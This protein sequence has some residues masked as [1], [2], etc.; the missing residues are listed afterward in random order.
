MEVQ[1]NHLYYGDNLDVLQRYIKDESVDLVYLDPPFNSNA[2]YNVLFAERNGQDSAAQIKAFEDTWRW[3]SESARVHQEIVEQGGKLSETL[4]AL[5]MILGDTDMLAYLTMMS[6]RLQE[7]RRVLKPTGSLYLHCDPTASHYL[8]LILDVIFGP[9]NYVNE[10]IWQRTASKGLMTRRLPRNHDVIFCY[11]MGE[12]ATRNLHETFK[13]YDVDNLDEKTGGKYRL[14]D[15]D[16][17]IYRL[18][19]LN[20]PN[21]NRPNLTYEFLGV[22][23]VWRW[24]KDRMEEAYKKGIVIQTAPGRVPQLKRYLDEQRG[25]PYGDVWADIFPINSQAAERLGYPTQKPLP[26]LERIIRISSNEGDTVLDPFC[27]CG[28]T[29]D[30]AERLKRN[31]IGIDITHLAVNL[32]KHRL[33]DTYGDP[34]LKTYRVIGEPTSV[35]DAETLAAEDPYQF[36]WW[37]L[38]LVGARPTETKKG[39]DH[40]IDGKLFFHDETGGKTKQIIF[41]VK[42]GKTSVAHV[43]DLRG[44]VEREKA[45]IGVLVSFQEPT[46]PMRSEAA[47]SGFYQSPWGKHPKIQLLTIADLLGGKKVDMPPSSGHVNVTFKKAKRQ[48]APGH[49]Q[50]EFE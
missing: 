8:K 20:N 7:L 32:I 42:A 17:R 13:A 47:G 48:N 3:D 39:A 36:Q 15:P 14:K 29:I 5:R 46:Q 45:E 27:G 43:R 50:T 37:A 2:D 22:T 44:V 12:N 16:G 9:K 11:Q 1:V 49:V 18:A 6:P 4:Q 31:W 35:P 41:S 19:D 23:R 26:L 21:H 40:G 24:T 10:I 25:R 28:T 33:Y 30:A 34:V 38:G